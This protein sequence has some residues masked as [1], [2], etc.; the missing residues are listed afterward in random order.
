MIVIGD[1]PHDMYL[2]V[3]ALGEGGGIAVAMNGAVTATMPLPIA[4]L[5]SDNTSEEVLEEYR[6]L[7]TAAGRL[8]CNSQIDP[9]MMLSFLPLPVIPELKLTDS[10]V[11]DVNLQQFY[12]NI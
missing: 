8:G 12:G 6:A 11:F 3:Q 1:N 5:M 4:G 7:C 10:G 9:F 2:A